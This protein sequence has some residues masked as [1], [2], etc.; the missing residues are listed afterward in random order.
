MRASQLFTTRAAP[1]TGPSIKSIASA[2]EADA[3][4]ASPPRGLLNPPKPD[5]AAAGVLAAWLGSPPLVRKG[6]SAFRT[7]LASV[8]VAIPDEKVEHFEEFQRAMMGAS[9]RRLAE[10]AAQAHQAA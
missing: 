4:S 1:A 2:A 6:V 7:A 8:H 3:G 9:V 5:L 10:V